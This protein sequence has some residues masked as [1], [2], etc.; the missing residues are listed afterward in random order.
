MVPSVVRQI[1]D[2]F[3]VCSPQKMFIM[4]LNAFSGAYTFF[5]TDC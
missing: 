2:N 5:A 1:V 3:S 4:P